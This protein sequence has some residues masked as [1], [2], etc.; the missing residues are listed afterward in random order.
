MI[1]ALSR[2]A[3]KIYVG[4]GTKSTLKNL[5]IT[6]INILLLDIAMESVV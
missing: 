5:E 3:G 4:A 2:P 1:P 6:H